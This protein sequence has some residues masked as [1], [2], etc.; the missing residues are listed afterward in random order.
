MI[1]AKT[2]MQYFAFAG[3]FCFISLI[4]ADIVVE[5]KQRGSNLHEAIKFVIEQKYLFSFLWLHCRYVLASSFRSL[6]L[7]KSILENGG[8]I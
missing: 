5:N 7:S 1:V 8:I 6:W 4:Q 2:K 3:L